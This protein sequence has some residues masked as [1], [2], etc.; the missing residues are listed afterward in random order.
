MGFAAN[1]ARLFHWYQSNK[2]IN[3][4]DKEGG[5][6]HEKDIINHFNGRDCDSDDSRFQF[7]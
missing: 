6:R 2:V 3:N 4:P 1:L 7:C 5:D